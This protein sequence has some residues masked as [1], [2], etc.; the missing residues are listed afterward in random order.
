MR[1]EMNSRDRVQLALNHK[2]ADRVP[3]DLGATVLTGIHRQSYRALRS[4]LGLPKVKDN[5]VDIFQQIVLVDDDVREI[6]KCDVRNVAPRPSSAFHLE[7]KEM[8]GYSYLYDE[9]GIGWKMPLQGGLYYD[10]FDHPL[11][12]AQSIADLEDYSWP[13]PL[14]DARFEGM[15]ERAAQAAQV[16]GQ[17]VFI[18]GMSAGIMEI[19]AWMRGFDNYFVDFAANEE[20]LV[21]LMRKVMEIKMAYW[22]RALTLIGDNVDA[23]HEADDFAGQYK[24]LISPTSYRRIVKPLHKELFDFIHDRTRAKLFFHSCGSIRSVIPDL[25]EIGVDILNPIQVSATGMDSAELKHEFGDQVVFWGGGVDTQ[26]VLGD[27]TPD[28]VRAETKRRIRDLAPGGGFV[29]ATVH[30]IQGNVPPENIIAM[31]ETLQEEG[32][33]S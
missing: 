18:G 6:L 3:F 32:V 22:D 4:Y 10:M 27:G 16:E 9:W 5:I 14:N 8:D 20:L 23:V 13:D 15:A 26:R 31:W 17:G 30:N 12:H 25:I 2:E 1:V 7:I 29:F 24:M 19:A 28:E 33:Y 11:A 21:A